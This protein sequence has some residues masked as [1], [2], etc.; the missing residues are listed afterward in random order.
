IS[1]ARITEA[2]SYCRAK[3]K[4]LI[5]DCC[6]AGAVV[7]ALGLKSGSGVP[8]EEITTISDS[9]LALMAS[10]RLEKTREHDS[11][12]GGF[13]TTH[14]CSALSGCFYEADTDKDNRISIQD[15]KRW[16]DSKALEH[17]RS[18]PN[19]RVPF[20]Y[21]SGQYK[22]EIFLAIRDSN[23]AMSGIAEVT[24]LRKFSEF[25]KKIVEKLGL[26][27]AE[28]RGSVD[29]MFNGF[30]ESN[31]D[32]DLSNRERLVMSQMEKLATLALKL[33]VEYEKDVES[34]YS[35]MGV[36][37]HR[38]S[39]KST[40]LNLVKQSFDPSENPL[41]QRGRDIRP[42][43][44]VDVIGTASAGF[45]AGVVVGSGIPI[46]GTIS[47]GITGLFAGA[48]KGVRDL[49][50]KLVAEDFPV[51][52]SY[53]AIR[54]AS[55]VDK[56]SAQPYEELVLL[57]NEMGESG[58][59]SNNSFYELSRSL[60]K[61]SSS[62]EINSGKMRQIF[63]AFKTSYLQGNSPEDSLGGKGETTNK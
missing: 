17:N 32:V 31:A 46:I 10:S 19:D 3:S 45:A 62:A 38:E 18:Y 4:L 14:I 56:I 21:L 43:E 34:L 51:V 55:F 5:L 35:A 57:I 49:N 26:A 48:G 44:I 59:I 8:V 20:P 42:M 58:L 28:M 61:E 37:W 30:S 47:G 53:C 39:R 9:Y 40:F 60:K 33:I 63:N 1:I 2:M 16:L 15:L 13:L 54:A 12:K 25:E 29:E 23:L 36:L 24:L 11:L 27:Y 41:S 7:N 6:H 52:K 50:K 22:G